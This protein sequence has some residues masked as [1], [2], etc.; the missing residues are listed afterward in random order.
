MSWWPRLVVS[1]FLDVSRKLCSFF[2]FH[3]CSSRYAT[4]LLMC[5]TFHSPT[6]Q[7]NDIS[8]LVWVKLILSQQ[9][10]LRSRSTSQLK[11]SQPSQLHGNLNINDKQWKGSR[12]FPSS[13][14]M[15]WTIILGRGQAFVKVEA[16]VQTLC[17][18]IIIVVFLSQGWFA[19]MDWY[20]GVSDVY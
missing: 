3:M 17:D 20:H 12:N 10:N 1:P 19:N 2:F 6:K 13:K 11:K 15:P 9:V 5:A 7:L 4:W 18:L 8:M 14:H 16:R